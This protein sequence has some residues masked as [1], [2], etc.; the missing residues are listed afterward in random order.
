M[1]N[2]NPRHSNRLLS[3]RGFLKA[4][5]A[6][7]AFWPLSALALPLR[8][9]PWPVPL[10]APPN[11]GSQGA[12]P[13]AGHWSPLRA[14]LSRFES[15]TH[16]FAAE[17]NYQTLRPSIES[18][19]AAIQGGGSSLADLLAEGFRGQPWLEGDGQVLRA[20]SGF[21]VRSY[22]ANGALL[23]PGDFAA[24]VENLLR[25]FHTL[26]RMEILCLQVEPLQDSNR[27]RSTLRFQ[28]A[29]PAAGPQL[30]ARRLQAG[31]EWLI[32]WISAPAGG[33]AQAPWRI[34]RWQTLAAQT[35]LTPATLFEDVTERA[36]GADPTYAAHLMR[37]TNYW[38]CVLDTASGVDIFGNC[39]VSAADIDGDGVDEIY[40]CQPQGLPNRLYKQTEPGRFAEVG[41]PAGINLLD[42]TSTALFADLLNRGSQDLILITESAPLLFLNDGRGRFTWSQ[43]AFPADPGL[44]SLTGA[45]LAD[46]NRDGFLDLYVCSYGYFQGQGANPLPTP[47][48]DARNG[49]P[50]HLYRSRGD[51]TFEDATEASGLNHGNHRFSFACAWIDYD[52]DGWPDLAVVNDF[53]RNNL[54]HNRRNGTFEE[55]EDGLSGFGSGMSVSAADFDGDGRPDLYVGNMWTPA[56]LRT[57]RDPAF[58]GRFRD[59]RHPSV[60]QF[61]MGNALYHNAGGRATPFQPTMA[62]CEGRWAWCSDAIDLANSGRPDLYVANG[63]LSGLTPQPESVD[64]WLWEEV[65]ALSP[66]NAS[67][68]AEYR[69]AWTAIF[70]L[71][72]TGHDWNGH[73]RNVCFLNLGGGQFADISAASG[74]DFTDD[75]RSF[76]IFDFDGDGDQDIVLHSRT[77]PQLRLLRNHAAGVNRSLALCLTARHGN[78]DAIG[79]RIEVRTPS[80]AQV[81]W[82]Q[83]GSGFLAQHSKQLA[84][85]LGSE[86]RARVS[87]T[88]PGGRQQDFGE[89]EAGYRYH[90]IEGEVPPRR[91]ALNRSYAADQPPANP[92][93]TMVNA[94]APP[95]RFS[96]PLINALPLP[97]LEL[98]K[99]ISVRLHSDGKLE[100]GSRALLWLW[101]GLGEAAAALE[102][103]LQAQSQLESRL[104]LLQ[105]PGESSLPSLPP[106]LANQLRSPAFA[107][108]EPT[109]QF[110]ST[111]LAY[112]FDYRRPAPWP[113][114]LLVEAEGSEAQPRAWNLRKVYWGGAAAAEILADRNRHFAS[115]SAALPFAGRALAC[116]FR[117]DTRTL[118]S[119]LAEAALFAQAEPYL[120]LAAR[121]NPKDAETLYNLALVRRELGRND[122]AAAGARAA[123]EARPNFA[124]A[125]NLLG[126]LLLDQGQF[127]AA[128]SQFRLATQQS[129]DFVE[130]WNNLG[131]AAMQRGDA[132]AA[133]RAFETALKLAPDFTNTL[134]NLGIL[135][136]KAGQL[137]QAQKLFERALAA[138]PQNE[139]AANNLGVLYYHEGQTEKARATLAALLARNPQAASVVMNLA[140][141]DAAT[142][143]AAAGRKLL[144]DWLASHPQDIAARQL[145]NQMGK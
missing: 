18:L 60:Q 80:G 37:D 76:A 115:G 40:L 136:A 83:C 119:A 84:F 87:I 137:A 104:I 2:P 27:L 74:I 6:G 89:L 125:A 86:A 9:Y 47:Y 66:H 111:L 143:N 33:A 75:G 54:Y 38:R 62:A 21:E 109:R 129:P 24:S 108:D 114:G 71:A 23:S 59:V 106:V 52:Q 11:S 16:R 46:Y 12:P 116:S 120:A 31:G 35:A 57:T 29:G 79:A 15:H 138:D 95:S 72:H 81:R 61:A 113:T 85:G 68:S 55:V 93:A 13:V 22:A 41:G 19:S 49:P 34:A 26:D 45:T 17:A 4:G 69:A 105:P 142:G 126:V 36:F 123:L 64:A 14:A 51:G 20:D 92:A 25:R 44:T 7:L 88:W 32:E 127:P 58:V 99:Q 133:R 73:E 117:S 102:P 78:R 39:G 101:D 121:A 56:G 65:V 98:L 5:G 82:L 63:F 1:A 30:H 70:Q 112:L 91:E 28:M 67:V 131:Y 10:P 130:A 77:G 97:P 107:A 141:L 124:E 139:Q 135:N 110:F 128:E 100:P 48:F 53:G 3:R 103:L 43:R 140:R 8:P 145:L 94:E 50:N 122:Q 144:Q 118:G 96:A 42:A 132:A 134:N 90:L